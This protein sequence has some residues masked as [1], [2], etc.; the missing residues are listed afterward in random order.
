M[1]GATGRHL[2]APV[3]SLGVGLT[4]SKLSSSNDL[5]SGLMAV[6]DPAICRSGR[7]PKETIKDDNLG[8]LPP[9]S[10]KED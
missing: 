2:T 6:L 4:W 9:V 5:T 8:Q 3:A 10:Q 1:T 7:K